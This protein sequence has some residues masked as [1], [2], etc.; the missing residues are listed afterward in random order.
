MVE[1]TWVCPPWVG[2]SLERPLM[3]LM[4]LW[5]VH[6][7]ELASPL[8]IEATFQQTNPLSSSLIYSNNLP[9]LKNKM[10]SFSLT[11]KFR[12]RI[13]TSFSKCLKRSLQRPRLGIWTEKAAKK[14]KKAKMLTPNQKSLNRQC[15]DRKSPKPIKTGSSKCW[16][17]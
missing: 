11:K 6:Y 16:T 4:G 5:L 13:R 10:S 3:L 8:T 14:M 2:A 7:L 12:L 9:K 15:F 17:Q 1:A